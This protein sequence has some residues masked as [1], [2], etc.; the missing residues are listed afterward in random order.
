MKILQKTSL[1]LGI[2]AALC[3]LM[4]T[5]VSA[6]PAAPNGPIVIS[7]TA[8]P[9]VIDLEYR[10][11]LT[12]TITVTNTAIPVVLN[13]YMKDT[14]PPMLT[15]SEWVTRP[16]IGTL[17]VVGDTILWTGSLPAPPG[18]PTPTTPNIITFTFTANLPG[19]ESMT[20][21][22]ANGIVN[23]AEVG[24]MDGTVYIVEDSD[25]AITRIRRSIYLPLVMRNFA[26]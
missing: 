14:L 25:S 5:V 12:Y 16:T 24:H 8:S 21:L 20:L 17:T 11:V 6:E 1:V 23:T 15:F 18:M 19:P 4:V 13:A 22:L 7:K 10:G 3:A 9:Q 2:V 26:Q